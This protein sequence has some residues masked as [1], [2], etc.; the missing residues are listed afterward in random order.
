MVELNPEVTRIAV[1]LAIIIAC[2]VLIYECTRY[3]L[4][5]QTTEK[6]VDL[7]CKYARTPNRLKGT[8]IHVLGYNEYSDNVE[9]RTSHYTLVIM[10]D[11]RCHA[12][13]YDHR[14]EYVESCHGNFLSIHGLIGRSLYAKALS[15]HT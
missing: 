3:W 14:D 1:I 2:W 12:V 13:I 9:I 7:Y 15:N 5:K 4:S 6:L 11:L 8:G 10:G